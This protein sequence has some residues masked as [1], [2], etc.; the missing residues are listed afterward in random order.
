MCCGIFIFACWWN[1]VSDVLFGVMECIC[2]YSTCMCSI[3]FV[4]YIYKHICMFVLWVCDMVDMHRWYG[5]CF[6]VV[7]IREQ[8]Y[9]YTCV[10]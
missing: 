6:Y 3:W 1:S 4:M 5:I 8:W 9:I 2:I 7:T 10:L